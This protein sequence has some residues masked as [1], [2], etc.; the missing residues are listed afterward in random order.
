V[1]EG[2]YSSRHTLR[3]MLPLLLFHAAWWLMLICYSLAV[4]EFMSGHL[5][6]L[7]SLYVVSSSAFSGAFAS[8]LALRRKIGYPLLPGPRSARRTVVVLFLSLGGSMLVLWNAYMY[9]PP[10]LLRLFGATTEVYTEYGRLKAVL[11]ALAT[12]LLVM[13]ASEPRL[14]HRSLLAGCAFF[15]FLLYMARGPLML[16]LIQYA[17]ART[18]WFGAGW[19]K[20]SVAAMVPVL[21]AAVLFGPLG[22]ARSGPGY[23]ATVMEIRPEYQHWPAVIL[24]LV[25]Y[26]SLPAENLVSLISRWHEWEWGRRVS[27]G[28]LP[29]FL[30]SA[31][32]VDERY[33][34]TLPNPLNNVPTYLGWVWM[35]FGWLG[36][37]LLNVI[38]GFAGGMLVERSP[39]RGGVASLPYY[40]SVATLFFNDHFLWFP[41]LVQMGAAYG[42]ERW[43]WR[44]EKA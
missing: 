12:L 41:T 3:V 5:G 14:W 6:L 16:A 36:I 10:P 13:A 24:W 34:S 8:G 28:V 2:S 33:L 25:G 4:A 9:G 29:G 35:D 39:G 22:E 27:L 7:A 44:G 30:G 43:V 19:K 32:R 20:G 15:V 26:V 42:I 21:V 1:V 17:L 31:S 40:A 18:L 38:W 37:V 11:F 23:F